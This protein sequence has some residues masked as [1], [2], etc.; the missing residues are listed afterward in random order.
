[1]GRRLE[2]RVA[3][4]AVAAPR[5]AFAIAGLHDLGQQRFLVL[6]EHLGARRHGNHRV[7]AGNTGAVLAH[8]ALAALRLEVL[9]VAVVDQRVEIG[10]AFQPYVAAL[11][12]VAAIG[13]AELD[14]LLT[15]ERDG[16]VTACA[17]GNVDLG[18]VEK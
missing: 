5:E 6:G 16:A 12:A 2:M 18:L 10:D 4:T 11:A 14:E 9:A 17:G 7:L 8:A 3:K 1:V 13:T 15:P